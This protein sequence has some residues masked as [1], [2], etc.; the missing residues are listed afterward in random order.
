MTRKWQYPTASRY[1]SA[2]ASFLSSEA[3]LPYFLERAASLK[4]AALHLA[5]HNIAGYAENQAN[6]ISWASRS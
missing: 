4:A 3:N 6:A 5:T 1:H 2:M